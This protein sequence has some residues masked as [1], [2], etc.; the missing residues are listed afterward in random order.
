MREKRFEAPRIY[1]MMITNEK[2]PNGKRPN[3][4]IYS[5]E[6]LYLN[7]CVTI[8]R[9][10][11]DHATVKTMEIIGGVRSESDVARFGQ[12]SGDIGLKLKIIFVVLVHRRKNVRT[13]VY[14]ARLPLVW[15]FAHS[16]EHACGKR[17]GE[18]DVAK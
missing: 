10:N 3:D 15:L 8:R 13:F 6:S 1:K 2:Q 11:V 4:F 14:V 5:F 12:A 17:E 7:L 18:R 9:M 16:L